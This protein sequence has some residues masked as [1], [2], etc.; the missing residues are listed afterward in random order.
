MSRVSRR[1]FL[2]TAASGAAVTIVGSRAASHTLGANE[3]IR[4]GVVGLRG[5][6]QLH[7]SMVSSIPGFRLAAV[8]DVDPAVLGGVVETVRN[9]GEQIRGFQD[10]R[11]LIAC[12][13]VDAITVATP[14]K[15][16][17]RLALDVRLRQ[18]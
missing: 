6:G 17:L 2:A 8:C 11:D 5:R 4:V 15:S 7:M 9:R 10:V 13:D 1:R 12:K 14:Q 18:R 3:A 16:A